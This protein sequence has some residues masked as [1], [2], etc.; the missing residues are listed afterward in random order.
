MAELVDEDEH[1]EYHHEGEDGADRVGKEVHCVLRSPG[2]PGVVGSSD[3]GAGLG[4]AL[5]T[6][7][8]GAGAGSSPRQGAR[9]VV[10]YVH[11]SHDALTG[12]SVVGRVENTGGGAGTLVTTD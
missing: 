8:A 11:L 9:E 3:R 7:G 6:G 4:Q 10:L 5:A 1:A 2:S 12:T